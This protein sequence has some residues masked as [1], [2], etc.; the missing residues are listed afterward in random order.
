MDVGP[1]PM[2]RA[3]R[4]A[5]RKA[6]SR[7]V[8]FRSH[9][10]RVTAF[11]LIRRTPA[12]RDDTSP[13]SLYLDW[14]HE[15]IQRLKLEFYLDHPVL[16][17]VYESY[18]GKIDR[19]GLVVSFLRSAL[20]VP[21]DV[22]EFGVYRGHTAAA[23]DRALEQQSS[24]KRLYLFDS[25]SGM[26]E[27]TH[28][29]DSAWT[30]G[31]LASPVENIRE[32]LKDSP[33][34]NIVAGYFSET[35]PKYPDLRFSFCHVDCDLYDSVKECITYIIPRLS[36]GG[37]IM[38]DDYGFRDTLGAK[39]AVEECLGK[40]QQNFVPLPTAQAV[41]FSRPGDGVPHGPQDVDDG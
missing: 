34:A 15:Q 11:D 20:S 24:D 10:F 23:M 26:P 29:L 6:L 1:R 39:A 13:L 32:L 25:F 2:R 21:G 16:G 38:F 5:L 30:K 35:L 41:Y 3:V 31:D 27:V 19:I 14:R 36:P 33:R 4:T 40:S 37:I 12:L 18:Y 7:I 28:P 8:I 9:E 17:D 22:G